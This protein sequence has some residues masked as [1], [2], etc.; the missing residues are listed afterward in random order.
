M[1]KSA[2][3]PV[4]SLDMAILRAEGWIAAAL[5]QA[6]RIEAIRAAQQAFRPVVSWTMKDHEAAYKALALPGGC[7][8][9]DYD[10]H[11]FLFAIRLA[12]RWCEIIL[13]AEP[14]APD[15][16]RTAAR[17]L[18]ASIGHAKPLRDIIEHED[19]YL[20]GGGKRP[21][22]YTVEA[23]GM[24]SSAHSVMMMGTGDRL[25]GGRFSVNDAIA[26]LRRA[27]PPFVVAVGHEGEPPTFLDA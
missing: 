9:E 26:A 15:D 16:V 7:L 1:G 14:S 2:P 6:K 19:E 17:E 25:L 18:L 23:F 5:L 10:S 27:L 4:P 13:E 20:A 24:K 3:K 11:F 8:V 12:L 21:G 22:E